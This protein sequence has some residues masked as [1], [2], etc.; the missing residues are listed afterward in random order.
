MN[1]E[2]AMQLI[3]VLERIAL[4]LK[5]IEE[6]LSMIIAVDDSNPSCGSLCITTDE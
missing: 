3:E 6:D 1:K 5:E 4:S 2:L